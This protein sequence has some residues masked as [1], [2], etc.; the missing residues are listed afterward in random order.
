MKTSLPIPVFILV[1][2]FLIILGMG[3]WL[4]RNY[5]LAT[6]YLIHFQN[7]KTD[8]VKCMNLLQILSVSPEA[9][10]NSVIQKSYPNNYY[11]V[12]R[13]TFLWNTYAVA[14]LEETKKSITYHQESRGS[15]LKV[16]LLKKEENGNFKTIY[17]CG[18][19]L[20]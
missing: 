1:L 20:G 15:T 8:D 18:K 12:R 16:I 19:F 13:S 14:E 4:N 7:A 5:I 9:R 10:L 2:L 3:G 17:S 6:S 11:K